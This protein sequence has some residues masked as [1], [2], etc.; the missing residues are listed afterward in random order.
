MNYQDYLDLVEQIR[1][2]DKLYY[3]DHAPIISD[4]EYDRLYKEL[5]KIEKAHPE[6]VLENSPTKRIAEDLSEGF[7]SVS[8]KIPMLSLANTYSKEEVKEFIGRVEKGLGKSDIPFEID[9]KM[10]GIAVSVHYE[11]GEFKRAL[12]RGDGKKGD[13]ITVNMRTIVSLP[14]TLFGKNI[15]DSLE[16]RGEVYMPKKI[17]Q[18]L[19]EERV[20]LEEEPW[21]N[22][23][24]AAG[25]ALKLLDPKEVAKR[26]LEVVFY[27][28]VEDSSHTVEEQYF[29]LKFMKS[30]GLP[31]VEH[32][33]LCHNFDEIWKFVESIEKLRPHLSYDIDGVV[34]KVNSLKEQQELGVTGK[35]PRF[36]VAYKFAA[37][38]AETVINQITVQVGRTGVLTP[39]AELEPVFLAGS[40]IARATLHNQEEIQRKDIRIG[41]TVIIEKG[42]DVIPKVVSVI[43]E[44]RDPASKPWHMPKHCPSCHS[45]VVKMEEEVAFRCLN[46]KNC[47]E[48]CLKRLIFFSG[49]QGMDIENMGEKV[50]E[51]LFQKGFVKRYSDIYRLTEKELAKLD[52]FKQKSINNLLKSIEKSKQVTLS[53]F[54]MA[55]GIKHIGMG[56]AELLAEKTRT[57]EHL[58]KITYEELISINGVGEKVA[59]EVVDFFL[60]QENLSEIQELLALGVAP[61]EK[62]LEY[63]DHLFNGKLFVLTGTLEG[64]TRKECYDLI[65]LRGG[66]VSETVGKK[67]NYLVVGK[68]P[69]SKLEKAKALKIPILDEEAFK[70]LL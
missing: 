30:L 51:Q 49:K 27:G 35:T 22:P 26:G 63:I 58:I 7:M 1:Y 67:T 66:S 15:P 11:K 56:T 4:Q 48:Q 38:Q 6:W 52:N 40:R 42:G 44:K 8:H 13:D 21:A 17:F 54:I 14:L 46:H 68:D 24:N 47:Y 36:A 20:Q 41:D 70:Q 39:V 33:K 43:L 65:K 34:I 18:A 55:L 60:D 25:G 62:S 12:T 53:K 61:E 32:A 2:H 5:E 9:L 45:L 50:V 57:M 23:R 28:V 31:I 69:G 19:N 29:A 37:E 3:V 10:D 64:F 59:H 16:V